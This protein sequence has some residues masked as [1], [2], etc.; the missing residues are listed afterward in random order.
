MDVRVVLLLP[1]TTGPAIVV[2]QK[3]PPHF[4]VLPNLFGNPDIWPRALSPFVTM[5]NL[6]EKTLPIGI[7]LHVNTNKP[8][9]DCIWT[10][11]T[12]M[13]AQKPSTRSNKCSK[14]FVAV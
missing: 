8:N 11:V 3:N 7:I 12:F 5:D 13:A 2:A 1:R 9:S 4:K 14:L 10:K 6:R